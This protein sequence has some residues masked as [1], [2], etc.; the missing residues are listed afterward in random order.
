[1]IYLFTL[2]PLNFIFLQTQRLTTVMSQSTPAYSNKALFN[3]LS[4]QKPPSFI[5]SVFL[6]M[7]I[8]LHVVLAWYLLSKP[9]IDT[10]PPATVIME[11]AL[12]QKTAPIIKPV[13]APTPPPVKKEPE[14]PKPII[15]PKPIK[16]PVVAKK[17]EPEPVPAEIK[18]VVPL[19]TA[20]PAPAPPAPAVESSP[21][22][23]NNAPKA[24][25]PTSETTAPSSAVVALFRVPPEYPARAANRHIEGWVKVEFTVQT[26]GSVED[27]V[28]VSAEPEDIF[29]DAAL[30]AISK[31]R[32]KEKIVNGV[33][34][35][36]RAVQKLQFKLEH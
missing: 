16:Q 21:A 6:A 33:A 17:P 24:I 19:Q 9:K 7:V 2:I 12:V 36:Q 31:W 32:F 5:A 34:V 25:G 4:T 28:V 30:T 14:K 11:V 35:P 18:D 3:P 20:P 13:A 23:T 27:A 10:T 29:N 1:M 26:D 22:P 15:K 8:C